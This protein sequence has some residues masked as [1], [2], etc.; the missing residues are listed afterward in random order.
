LL[1]GLYGRFYMSPYKDDY[2]IKGSENIHN[3]ILNLYR[4]I[5]DSYELDSDL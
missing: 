4:T 5:T 2:V 1:N 3:F